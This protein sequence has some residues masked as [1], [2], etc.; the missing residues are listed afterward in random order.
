MLSTRVDERR[1]IENDGEPLPRRAIATGLKKAG[2][3]K[4]I[5]GWPAGDAKNSEDTMKFP[6]EKAGEAYERMMSN[7]ARFRVVLSVTE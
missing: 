5:Q 2:G 3:R 1:N 6:L 7:R 4:S